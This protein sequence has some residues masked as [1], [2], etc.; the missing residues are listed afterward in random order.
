MSVDV[1]DT[2]RHPR[3][4]LERHGWVAVALALGS[5]LAYGALIV[6]PYYVNGLNGVPLAE[7]AGGGHDPKDLW[8]MASPIAAPYRIA[9]LFMVM[10]TP[11]IAMAVLMWAAFQ[12]FLTGSTARSRA[13]AATAAGISLGVLAWH[14]T[15]L[16]QAL[17]SW[18]LD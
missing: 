3:V 15:P 13:L 2:V 7:V 17:G 12:L 6:L 4:P 16:G 11:L 10:L 9:G 14:A 1:L 18:M 5:A 8:P